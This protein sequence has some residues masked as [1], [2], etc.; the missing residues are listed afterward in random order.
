MDVEFDYFCAGASTA[1]AKLETHICQLSRLRSRRD[2][3]IAVLELG[4]R[5]AVSKRKQR[6]YIFLIEITIT[7]VKS[8]GIFHLKLLTRIMSIGW[9]IFPL[10]YERNR[11]LSRGIHI[12]EQDVSNGFAGLL[13]AVPHV[14]KRRNL[15]DPACH[16]DGPACI[17]HDNRFLID[18]GDGLN[19]IVLPRW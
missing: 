10:L 3:Q 13:P 2:F 14:E 9:R 18:L 16:D 5:E 19:Q 8:L 4:V 1:I 11:K 17:E 12:A 6:F 15:S 7:D